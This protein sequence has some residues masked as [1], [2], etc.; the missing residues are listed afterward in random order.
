MTEI[1]RTEPTRPRLVTVFGGTGFLGRRIVRRLLDRGVSVRIAARHPER[2]D[3]LFAATSSLEAARTDIRDEAA[4]ERAV[5]NATAVVNAVSLYVESG[6]V[7][8]EAIHVEGAARAARCARDAGAGLLV[9]VSG[10]GADASSTSSY[11]RARGR[12]EH[13]VLEA[14]PRAVLVRPAVMVAADDSFLTTLVSLVRRLPIYPL[15][16]SGRTRMQPL[17]VDDVGEAAVRLVFEAVDKRVQRYEFGGPRVYTYRELVESVAALADTRSRP[18]PVPFALWSCLGWV[19]ERL[20]DTPLTRHQV[21]LMRHDNVA[22]AV[23][24]GLPSLDVVPQAID[25]AVRE[26]AGTTVAR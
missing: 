18:V 19:G 22:S 17:H 5:A 10:I 20:P 12:G 6:S 16:G 15:F 26:I 3:A 14:F 25:D 23:L 2:A 13:A 1:G 7:T 8:F 11:I 9:H 21:E 4:V 24:P